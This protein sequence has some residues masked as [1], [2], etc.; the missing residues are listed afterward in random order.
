MSKS[1]CIFSA[2]YP[3]H[4]GGI[5]K[6]TEN[7]TSTLNELGCTVT[8]VTSKHSQSLATFEQL[9]FGN[10]VRLPSM[11]FINGRFPVLAPSIQ[12]HQI[13]KQLNSIHFDLIIVNTRYYPLSLLGFHL[14]KKTKTPSILIDHSS[15]FLT[16]ERGPLTKTLR[17]YEK[18]FTK[19]IDKLYNPDCYG[20]SQKSYR[21]LLTLGLKARGILPNSISTDKF[22]S[23]ASY[24][25]FKDEFHI[26]STDFII[27][28]AGRLVAGKGALKLLEACKK[29]GEAAKVHLFIAGDG[30]QFSLLSDSADSHIH[31]L[32]RLS[33]AD[34][35]ALLS[36]T[37]IF[38]FPSDYPEGL[39]TALLEAGS[40]ACAIVMSNTGGAEDLIPSRDFGIV[41]KSTDPDEIANSLYF[42][43]NNPEQLSSMG[44]KIQKRI[45]E[46][47]SWEA[48]AKEILQIIRA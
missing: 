22:I 38:C 6:Y 48:T 32:G 14:S 28:F 2:F 36:Q 11:L 34:L 1:I 19:I 35:S 5:E 18:I 39:P 41:L 15:A 27:T 46:N 44:K 26:P 37:D 29:L 47:F 9:H 45:K 43:I 21:W 33:S 31:I 7:L 17:L 20:V 24:R 16:L 3:P 12:L 8:V 30:E 10:L 23:S 42:L 25:N 13:W 40:H 4:M